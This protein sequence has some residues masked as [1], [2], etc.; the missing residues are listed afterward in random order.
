MCRG[1]LLSLEGCEEN[2]AS[3]DS[4]KANNLPANQEGLV[5]ARL[6]GGDKTVISV[7]PSVLSSDTNMPAA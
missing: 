4:M 3:I 7:P 2:V 5:L 1:T 6:N